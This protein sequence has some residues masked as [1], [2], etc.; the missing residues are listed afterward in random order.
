MTK[1]GRGVVYENNPLD[2]ALTR[3]IFALYDRGFGF[4]QIDEMLVGCTPGTAKKT[5]DLAAAELVSILPVSIATAKKLVCGGIRG[6]V[7]VL[8][9]HTFVRRKP[10]TLRGQLMGLPNVGKKTFDEI[11][12]ALVAAKWVTQKQW[13]E[14]QSD[15]SPQE[16]TRT[17]DSV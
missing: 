12:T 5:I 8:G 11:G 17:G 1:H 15:A 16:K 4:D 2:G 7:D 6:K 10:H 9:G 13:E 3:A 14:A